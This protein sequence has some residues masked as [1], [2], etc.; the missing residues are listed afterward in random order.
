M[1]V[2][3]ILKSKGDRVVTVEPG[4]TV[5][6]VAATLHEGVAGSPPGCFAEEA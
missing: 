4:V 6:E 2:S 3:D 5:P 1:Q